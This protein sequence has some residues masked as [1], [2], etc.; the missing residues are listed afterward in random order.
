MVSLLRAPG[1]LLQVLQ[2]PGNKLLS[3]LLLNLLAPI[4]LHRQPMQDKFQIPM[5]CRDL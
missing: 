4:T 5:P 1:D 3:P 2:L